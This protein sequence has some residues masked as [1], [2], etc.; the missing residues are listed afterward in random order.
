MKTK[1][2]KRQR[3]KHHVRNRIM[4]DGGG[5]RLTV[6]RSSKH[7]YAQLVD[8]SG[9]TLCGA[10]TTRKADG[11]A[12]SGKSKTDRAMLV[13]RRIAELAREKGIETVVFDRG[14]HRFHGRVKALAEA[15]R[16]GGLK[17]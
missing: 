7:I 8:A 13:G 9:R 3:R 17:F 14:S 5:L 1:L 11:P 10:G 2:E 12:L 4:R 16:A 6:T 15:A